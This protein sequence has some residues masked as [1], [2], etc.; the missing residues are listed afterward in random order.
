LAFVSLI[1]EK[2]RLEMKKLMT[3]KMLPGKIKL[4][5]LPKAE[6]EKR[7]PPEDENCQSKLHFASIFNR[8]EEEN[9]YREVGIVS[10]IEIDNGNI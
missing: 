7:R 5:A 2:R 8:S 4:L 9:S 3:A 1:R 10:G 6:R